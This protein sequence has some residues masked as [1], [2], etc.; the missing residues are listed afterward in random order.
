[1]IATFTLLLLCV[2]QAHAQSDR[3]FVSTAGI[4]S[5]TCG[6][7]NSP[8]RSF[9]VALP[10]TNGGGTVTALDSGLYDSFNIWISIPV[11]LTAA[12]GVHAEVPGITINTVTTNDTVVLRNLYVSKRPG[13]TSDDG[14]KIS[15]VGSLHI[16]N[17]VV[18]GFNT[19]INFA[20]NS[21]AQVVISDTIVRNSIG[22]GI[23]FSTNTGL[24]KAVI[25]HCRLENNG[26]FGPVGD[27]ISVLKRSRVT[28]R[29]TVAAGNSGAGFVVTGGELNL[30]N[31]ES[32][33]NA[34][35]RSRCQ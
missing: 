22:N 33:N 10:N 25:N 18:N 13:V 23:N 11:T 9:N 17:C 29:D 27:G 30:E 5:A 2:S 7:F 15:S 26:N 3:A 6:A 8:C 24:I 4:D 21:S 1:M 32:S 28:V 35:G 31:C 19:G 14:F 20:I 16:E 34:D 12:P